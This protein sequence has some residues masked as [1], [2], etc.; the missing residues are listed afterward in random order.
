MHPQPITQMASSEMK[1]TAPNGIFR[2]DL[3][4][5]PSRNGRIV[6]W[7]ASVS[8]GATR[9]ERMKAKSTV[10]DAD[11]SKAGSALERAAARARRLAEQAGTPLYVFKNGH[12]VDLNRQ[13]AGSY[14]LREGQS[15]K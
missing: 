12:V 4:I 15:G 13:T 7:D 6:C 8:A 11:M 5:R 1:N 2:V 9:Q 10:A 3:H 14:A